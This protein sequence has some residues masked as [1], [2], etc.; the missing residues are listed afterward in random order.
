[1]SEGHEFCSLVVHASLARQTV[2]WYHALAI[3]AIDARSPG[4]KYICFTEEL[5]V[6]GRVDGMVMSQTETT[7]RSRWLTTLYEV[8][9]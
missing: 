7:L 4:C 5:G 8:Q 6:I 9:N 2:K 3:D 1:M